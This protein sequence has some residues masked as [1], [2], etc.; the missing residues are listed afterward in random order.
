MQRRRAIGRDRDPLQARP[1]RVERRVVGACDDVERVALQ[2]VA[3]ER[4]GERRAQP[5]LVEPAGD[6]RVELHAPRPGPR[7][8]PAGAG[9]VALVARHPLDVQLGALIA[10]P[11][12]Q[13]PD[14]VLRH[15]DEIVR[16]RPPQ[17]VARRAVGAEGQRRLLVDVRLEPVG[18]DGHVQA[19]VLHL[20]TQHTMPR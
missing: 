4:R 9:L 1:R 5:R 14:D 6:P 18:V 13:Q 16:V 8:E 3:S 17:R 19:V 2:A 20:L 15:P 12:T 11:A 10:L 7:V